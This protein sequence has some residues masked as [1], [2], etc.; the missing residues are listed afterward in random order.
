MARNDTETSERSLGTIVKELTEDITTLFR[1]EILPGILAD[2]RDTIVPGMTH[3][4]H[5]GWFAYFPSN[6]S[7]PSVL[8]EVLASGLGAQCMSWE[9]SPAATALEQTVNEHTAGIVF[10]WIQGEG[11]INPISDEFAR[12]AREL[13]DRYNALLVFDEIQ[14]G[15]GR[16]GKHFAYQL[17][18]PVIMPGFNPAA[19]SLA[20]M[21]LR[22][23]V[24]SSI[25][26]LRSAKLTMCW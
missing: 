23:S 17:S 18:E 19:S 20:K 3:W 21:P 6:S 26:A 13:A 7:P 8:G 22:Y 24:R 11:G 10:E 15:V 5:P 12:K 14:C 9:T 2:F 16:T 4:G 1:G 25:S